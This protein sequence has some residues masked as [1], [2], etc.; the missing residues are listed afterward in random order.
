[1]IMATGL[2]GHA[3]REGKTKDRVDEERDALL[4][5]QVLATI[6]Y[7]AQ[8]TLA[9]SYRSLCP[10]ERPQKYTISLLLFS[11]DWRLLA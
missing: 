4:L 6:E 7:K 2:E 11:R 10:R 8:R 1:M 3:Q 5:P 9:A